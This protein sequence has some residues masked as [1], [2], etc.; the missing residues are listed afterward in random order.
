M[1]RS[2]NKLLR[3]IYTLLL[4]VL[5]S[6]AALAA[7]VDPALD[8]RVFPVEE[9]GTTAAETAPYA[10]TVRQAA[11]AVQLTASESIIEDIK[12]HEGFVAVPYADT[13]GSCI[14]YGCQYYLAE[15]LWGENFVPITEEQGD[16]LLRYA[17]S[18]IEKAL[19]SFLARNGIQV[20]QNQFDALASFTYNVGIGWTTYKNEDGTWCKL[21]VMLLEGPSAWTE[22]R[23]QEAFGAW[24]YAN[25]QVLPGLVRLRAA[26][27]TLFCTPVTAPSGPFTDVPENTWYTEWVMSAY[28]KD[29]MHGV[30]GGLFL[31]GRT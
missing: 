18:A 3:V 20:N 12:R 19:N 1:K 24:V 25:G 28:E 21:K 22:E 6:G 11:N 31:P 27:A 30:G 9:P 14:G 13:V 2:N 29:F 4:A 16:E 23:V 10:S 7:E 8:L 26:E 5:L 17:M 15:E